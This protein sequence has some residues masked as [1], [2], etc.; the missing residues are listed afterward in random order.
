[1]AN[2]QTAEIKFNQLEMRSPAM[3]ELIAQKPSL[4]SRFNMVFFGVI[5]LCLLFFSWMI[6]FQESVI[7][8]VYFFASNISSQEYVYVTALA[9]TQDIQKIDTGQ[10]VELTMNV[11]SDTSQRHFKGHVNFISKVSS[12]NAI[13]VK[14]TIINPT[15]FNRTFQTKSHTVIYGKAKIITKSKRLIDKLFQNHFEMSIK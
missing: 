6:K 13:E 10:L 14:I 3:Q 7:A 5:L 1:M 11:T 4:L 8:P 9:N 2:H 15:E 12:N